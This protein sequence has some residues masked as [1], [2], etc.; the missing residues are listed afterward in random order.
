MK[1]I[2]L[3]GMPGC[4]KSTIGKIISSKIG[5][6]FID[7]DLFI[8]KKSGK[9]IDELFSQGEE[10]FRKV[11]T[12]CL[13][14]V[15]KLDGAIIATGGGIVTVAENISV[16]RDSGKIIFINT[17]VEQILKNSALGGRPLLKNKNDIFSLYEKRKDLYVNS[18]DISVDNEGSINDAVKKI[19]SFL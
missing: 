7:L 15:S 14:E 18:A 17:P 5:A 12:A 8:V 4:G 13:R 3:I 2:Y 10:F 1:N 16:M 19:I 6:G 11:E 9:S